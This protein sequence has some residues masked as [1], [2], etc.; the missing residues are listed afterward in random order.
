AQRARAQHEV[1]RSERLRQ[2]A[3]DRAR[4]VAAA[5]AQP[6]LAILDAVVTARFGMAQQ[7]QPVHR[8]LRPLLPGADYAANTSPGWMT[9]CGRLVNSAAR[10]VSADLRRVSSQLCG[11]SQAE[12]GVTTSRPSSQGSFARYA[13]S[14]L[15]TGSTGGSCGKTSSPAPAMCPS[16]SAS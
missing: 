7:M 11:V 4:F 12:C 8:R 10:I 5:P 6:P 9:F 16:F 15:G 3:A 2:G 13:A 1:E 14:S